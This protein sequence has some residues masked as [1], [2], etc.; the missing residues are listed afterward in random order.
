MS[1]RAGLYARVSSAKQ[2][3]GTSLDGQI[4]RMREHAQQNGYVIVDEIR[5]VHTGVDPDRPGLNKLRELA[6]RGE[7]D[8]IVVFALDRFMRDEAWAVIVEE[9]L[10]RLGATIDFMDLPDESVA[11][12]KYMKALMRVFADEERQRMCKRMWRGR[13]DKVRG[14]NALVHSMPPYGYQLVTGPDGKTTLAVYEPEAKIVRLIYQWYTSEGLTLRAIARRL[15]EMGI[16]TRKDTMP[17]SGSYKKA[18]YGEWHRATVAKILGSEVYTGVWYYGKAGNPRE[19]WLPIS[20]PV[21]VDRQTWELAQK[22][23]KLNREMA[24]R[25]TKNEYLM[26]RRLTCG[27]CGAKVAG[28]P[29]AWRSKNAGGV[30][31]YYLCSARQGDIVGVTCDLPRFRVEDVDEAIW[32]WVEGFLLD[33]KSLALGLREKQA[34]KRRALEP[35][36][37]RVVDIDREIAGE[38]RRLGLAVDEYFKEGLLKEALAEKAKQLER[39]VTKLES[40]KAAL[41]VHLEANTITDEQ[42]E[43]L[44]QFA[45]RVTRGLKNLDFGEKRRIIDLLNVSGTLRLG[46]GQKIIYVRC[47]IGEQMIASTNT[48]NRSRRWRRRYR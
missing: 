28:H 13:Q 20:V 43:T 3:E 11:G 21:V 37:E 41:E 33:P 25:N 30:N 18:E 35:L 42:I 45:S 7:I 14:G 17:N 2:E 40:A 12:Y 44:E 36:R 29:S 6:G 1:K 19:E 15:T 8:T 46:E 4:R 9:E 26:G 47:E 34:E 23:R 38:K 32:G 16:P 10:R 31:L 39:R 24:S 48:S 22:R 5:E 27:H